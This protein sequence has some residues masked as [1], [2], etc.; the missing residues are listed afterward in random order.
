VL[1]A[2]AGYD[3]K[4]KVLFWKVKNSWG[5]SWGEKG[6]IRIKRQTGKGNGV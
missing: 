5:S 2:G 6:Y 1:L 4:Q 3:T